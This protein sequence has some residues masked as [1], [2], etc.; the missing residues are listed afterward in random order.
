VHRIGHL[1]ARE[2]DIGASIEWVSL[3]VRKVILGPTI[4]E[5]K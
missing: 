1:L 3:V 5:L 4:F 2:E